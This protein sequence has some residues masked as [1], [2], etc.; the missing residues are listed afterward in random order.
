[1]V[2]SPAA[3]RAYSFVFSEKSVTEH[4]AQKAGEISRRPQETRTDS[5]AMVTLNSC[6]SEKPAQMIQSV[7]TLFGSEHCRNIIDGRVIGEVAQSDILE[8]PRVLGQ[9]P[10]FCTDAIIQHR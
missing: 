1:V 5:R 6:P 8:F 2:P 10:L 4:P 3:P 7:L 9:I